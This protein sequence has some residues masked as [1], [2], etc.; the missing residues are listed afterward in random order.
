M[1][2][3]SSA[4]NQAVNG[5]PGNEYLKEGVAV[6]SAQIVPT[7]GGEK[8]VQ[9]P[10]PSKDRQ[11]IEASSGSEQQSSHSTKGGRQ[12]SDVA[13]SVVSTRYKLLYSP[14]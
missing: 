2:T 10:H 13:A 12:E 5:V 9:D 14:G 6:N 8:K 4:S 1:A 7:N 11:A 3:G